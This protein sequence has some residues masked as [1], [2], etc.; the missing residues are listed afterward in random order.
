MIC[1]AKNDLTLQYE[2]RHTGAERPYPHFAD[3]AASFSGRKRAREHN[4]WSDTNVVRA[5]KIEDQ[6]LIQNSQNE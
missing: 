2:F 5:Q 4:C 3:A 6:I 1:I